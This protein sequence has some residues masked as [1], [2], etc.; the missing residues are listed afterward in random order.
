MRHKLLGVNMLG[1]TLTSSQRTDYSQPGQRGLLAA[2]SRK[3]LRPGGLESMSWG[4]LSARLDT[5]STHPQRHTQHRSMHS[6]VM[7]SSTASLLVCHGGWLQ[8]YS[9][10]AYLQHLK[11]PA[12]GH[13]YF[14]GVSSHL[15]EVIVMMES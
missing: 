10:L 2:I 7:R 5:T 12:E 4:P 8:L 3:A 1:N 9:L 15:R 11:R 6:R 13:L 14:A